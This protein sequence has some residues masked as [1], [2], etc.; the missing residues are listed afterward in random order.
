MYKTN[1]KKKEQIQLNSKMSLNNK[2]IININRKH[3]SL[4]NLN[5]TQLK[6]NR[7]LTKHD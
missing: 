3:L 4:L 6:I 1:H 2:S 7:R 5:Q